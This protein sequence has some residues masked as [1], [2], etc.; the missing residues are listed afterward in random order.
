MNNLATSIFSAKCKRMVATGDDSCMNLE[1]PFGSGIKSPMNVIS[2]NVLVNLK[3]DT[4]YL[5]GCRL[6]DTAAETAFSCNAE[7]LR[8]SILFLLA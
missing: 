2:L 4:G 8:V 1:C 6:R 5:V 7:A 3:D